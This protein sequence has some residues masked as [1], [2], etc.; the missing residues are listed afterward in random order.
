M[1]FSKRSL[2]DSLS[3]TLQHY[4]CDL[5]DLVKE[6]CKDPRRRK[7]CTYKIEEIVLAAVYMY[8]LRRGSRNSM[9]E[10][11]STFSFRENYTSLFGLRLPH[12]DTVDKVLEKLDEECLE[13]LKLMMVRKLLTKR[14]FHK[15]RLLGKYFTVAIDATGVFKYDKEPY[16]N[17]PYKVS[18]NGKKTYSQS[19]LEAK[20]LTP[21]GFSISL[22]TEW[23]VNSD[24]SRKQDCEQKAFH[25]LVERLHKD[26]PRLAICLLLDGLYANDPIMTQIESR[27]WQYII[28]WKD[29][30]MY[31]QQDEIQR[32]RQAGKLTCLSKEQYHNPSYK[33]T[34]DYESWNTALIYKGHQ[35]Y[36]A[37]MIETHI[38]I[39]DPELNKSTKFMFMSSIK[40]ETDNVEQIIK[41]GRL[42]WKIENEGFNIQKNSRYEMHHKMNW[43]SLRAL[44]NY[45][46]CLQ[47]AHLL[48][49]LHTKAKKLLSKI[50]YSVEKLWQYVCSALSMLD[51]YISTEPTMKYNYRY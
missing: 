36:Y 33:T 8:L 30:T 40:I 48:S 32:L 3:K 35:L 2:L 38:D 41:A 15:D 11:R 5:S 51:E 39:N 42:R 34:Q 4:Y 16:A 24:G 1:V 28:V 23:I 43:N 31:A 45:Y 29:K 10:D 22:G 25:R 37:K 7:S 21:T 12:M 47:I 9:N 13:K 26:Y 17:C 46:S 20:L 49:Q 18:K 50:T 14:T 27:G 6:C 44:K 19:I